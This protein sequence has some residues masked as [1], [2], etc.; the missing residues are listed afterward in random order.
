MFQ[1]RYSSQA[2]SKSNDIVRFGR[3]Y[4][5]HTSACSRTRTVRT[6]HID[7]NIDTF[8]V[9]NIKGAIV[10]RMSKIQAEGL[11]VTVIGASNRP[12]ILDAP[13]DVKVIN[14]IHEAQGVITSSLYLDQ[15]S[16][17]S[18]I[19]EELD[20]SIASTVGSWLSGLVVWVITFIAR[21]CMSPILCQV[22]DVAVFCDTVA[23]LTSPA[24]C[25]GKFP[26]LCWLL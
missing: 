24:V 4:P 18:P 7:Q 13:L 3:M 8:G 23:P 1:L 19:D 15:G 25:L 6:I 16:L 11:R 2:D 22:A 20:H 26:R 17:A 14:V 9:E 10:V 21:W 12:Y 5:T